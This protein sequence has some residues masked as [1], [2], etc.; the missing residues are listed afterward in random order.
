[1]SFESV[2]RAQVIAVASGK[3]GVGKTNVSVNL[4]VALAKAGERTMLVDCDMGLA[5]AAIVLGVESAFT[6]G[7]LLAGRCDMDDL[8]CA[9]PSGLHFVP[10]HSGTGSG[11]TL[12]AAERGRLI[13]ALAPYSADL[14]HIVID[15]GGGLDASALALVATADV[16]LIVVAPE[17]TSFLDAYAVVKALAVGHGVTRFRIVANMVRHDIAGRELFD[18]FRA[19]ATRFLD[20]ELSYAGAIPSDPYVRAAVARKSCCV[21][22]FPGAPASKAFARLARNLLPEP[23]P[24]PRAEPCLIGAAHGA[25]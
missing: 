20:V 10:G 4:A 25:Y 1:M 13:G 21:E 3:G 22:A 19:I 15:M 18:Q 24:A 11:S 16:P 12:S 14:D 2:S 6:I 8:V 23:T 7:D 9:G 5:N 17:P